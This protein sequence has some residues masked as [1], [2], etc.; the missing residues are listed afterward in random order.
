MYN[1]RETCFLDSE[2]NI[3]SDSIHGRFNYTCTNIHAHACP[4]KYGFLRSCHS[5]AYVD[6]VCLNL[7]TET[8]YP[9]KVNIMAHVAM[10]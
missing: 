3:L 4:V 2:N 9:T 8:M 5:G 6:I 1:V 10:W 7:K